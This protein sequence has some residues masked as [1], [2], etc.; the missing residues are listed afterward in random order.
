MSKLNYIKEVAATYGAKQIPYPDTF[1]YSS[2][3]WGEYSEVCWK[4][5]VVTYKD[6]HNEVAF[7]VPELR[8][9]SVKNAFVAVME[10]IYID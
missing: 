7:K 9:L 5:D 10:N 1:W 6:Y 4:G 2:Q 8:L 3:Y